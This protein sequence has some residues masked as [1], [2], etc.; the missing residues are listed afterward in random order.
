MWWSFDCSILLFILYTGWVFSTSTVC[1]VPSGCQVQTSSPWQPSEP[2][3]GSTASSTQ[4]CTA[5]TI[6][7]VLF[8]I[9]L[10]MYYYFYFCCWYSCYFT[11]AASMD[12]IHVSFHL[13]ICWSSSPC[14]PFLAVSH[15]SVGYS[16]NQLE[17]VALFPHPS[18]LCLPLWNTVKKSLIPLPQASFKR[19]IISSIP[20]WPGCCSA[21]CCWNITL[22][23][24]STYT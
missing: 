22:G 10:F 5:S 16:N 19:C 23:Q 21:K 2:M 3:V 15:S 13:Y 18:F 8:F 6:R 9:Y 7:M 11:A 20:S 14:F 17:Y 24:I 1:H 12:L 4:I